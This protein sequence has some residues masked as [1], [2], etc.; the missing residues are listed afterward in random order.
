MHLALQ[1]AVEF[2]SE[3]PK[4]PSTILPVTRE[5]IIHRDVVWGNVY[6]VSFL[7]NVITLPRKISS[8]HLLVDGPVLNVTS[9][10]GEPAD[11]NSDRIELIIQIGGSPD[12]ALKINSPQKELESLLD[13]VLIAL[14]A[15]EYRPNDYH[16]RICERII[17][18]IKQVD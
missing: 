18:V 11:L 6:H 4:R 8:L 17:E 15:P 13:E 10:P 3:L 1:K 2:F 9:M 12:N 5:P 7:R 14:L 16:L